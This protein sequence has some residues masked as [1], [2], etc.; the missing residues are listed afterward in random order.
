[1][2]RRKHRLVIEATF[3]SPITERDAVHGLQLVLDDRLDIQK[4]PVWARANSPYL[5]KLTVKAFTRV[6]SKVT[7]QLVN[8]LRFP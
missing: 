1:M 4:A 8:S 5:D 3:S 2:K 6:V 7:D